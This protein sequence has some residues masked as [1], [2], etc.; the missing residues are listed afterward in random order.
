MKILP[1]LR[2]LIVTL[3]A[4]AIWVQPAAANTQ[5]RTVNHVDETFVDSEICSF[6]VT[7][8]FAGSFTTTDFYDN[9][10]LLYKSLSTV[11]PGPFLETLTAKG[12]TLADRNV[13][14]SETIIYNPDG[15]VKT[16]TDNGAPNKFT[17][18]GSG[19]VWLEA[20]HLILDGHYHVLFVAGP[21]QNGDFDALCPAFG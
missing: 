8:H 6:G 13:A 2:F 9:T 1:N 10:G 20:G 11:G 16:L 15:S 17:A 18:P 3:A 19:I 5:V 7:V 14:F 21:H 4:M 12:T